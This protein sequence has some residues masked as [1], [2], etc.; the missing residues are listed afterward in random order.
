MQTLEPSASTPPRWE[1]LYTELWLG[2]IERY[3]ARLE[4]Y[5]AI[6]ALELVEHLE[7]NILSR[8]GVVTL[9]TYRPK[10]MMVS[11][12][13]SAFLQTSPER[14]M[15]LMARWFCRCGSPK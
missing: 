11:T 9:G 6:V 10:L 7:P 5:D 2:G 14:A 13:V 12:P 4:G 8:F 15:A 3:N 1:T